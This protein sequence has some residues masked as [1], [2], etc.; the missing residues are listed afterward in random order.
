MEHELCMVLADKNIQ[1]IVVR[2]L[3]KKMMFLLMTQ[4]LLKHLESRR[5]RENMILKRVG[6]KQNML[7]FLIRLID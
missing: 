7:I 3:L 4:K 5:E 6:S 1:E 2:S